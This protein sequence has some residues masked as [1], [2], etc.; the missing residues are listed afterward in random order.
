M[1]DLAQCKRCSGTGNVHCERMY[2]GERSDFWS[3]QCPDCQGTGKS[4]PA[5]T[6]PDT[7]TPA[8]LARW[9]NEKAADQREMATRT[10]H[11]EPYL[12]DS[13]KFI[14]C[15]AAITQATGNHKE[16]LDA[17]RNAGFD[18]FEDPVSGIVRV[19]NISTEKAEQE[20]DASDAFIYKTLIDPYS[21]MEGVDLERARDSAIERHKRSCQPPS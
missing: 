10:T 13:A 9:L 11:P 6:M 8:E 16:L 15:A 4:K 1:A 5:P 12:R 14:Q 17:V 20:R 21:R 7:P 2:H 18:A 19:K 3:E